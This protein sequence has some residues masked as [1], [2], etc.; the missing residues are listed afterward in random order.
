MPRRS[1]TAKARGLGGSWL[2]P[3][4]TTEDIARMCKEIQATWPPEEFIERRKYQFGVSAKKR[5]RQRE[6]RKKKGEL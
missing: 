3:D 4:P 2:H 6:R 5:M 1:D